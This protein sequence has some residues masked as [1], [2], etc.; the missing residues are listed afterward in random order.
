MFMHPMNT[1]LLHLN[2]CVAVS[3]HRGPQYEY[4]SIVKVVLVIVIYT[5]LIVYM[6]AT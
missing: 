3:G 6:V 1:S 4:R 2:T 5:V